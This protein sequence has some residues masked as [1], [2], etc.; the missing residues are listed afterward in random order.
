MTSINKLE[1]L[2]EFEQEKICHLL[3]C[4][5]D[6]LIKLSDQA[7]KVFKDTDTTYDTLTVSYTHLTLP[8]HREV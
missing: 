3:E 8:P 6:D 4:N 1:E 5:F 2:N 7:E